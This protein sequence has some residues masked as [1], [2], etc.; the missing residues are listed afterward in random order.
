MG[1]LSACGEEKVDASTPERLRTSMRA[2]RQSLP[3]AR[4][5]EFDAAAWKL[6]TGTVV[7]DIR[8]MA[9]RAQRGEPAGGLFTALDGLTAEEIIERANA[10][11][12]D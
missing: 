3:E 4:R 1:T 11:D 5:A 12:P 2:V 8:A 9:Q 6:A 10:R 7:K